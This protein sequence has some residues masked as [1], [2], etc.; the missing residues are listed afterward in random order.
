MTLE[1]RPKIVEGL[2]NF[3]GFISKKWQPSKTSVDVYVKAKVRAS[4]S[5]AYNRV[6]LS[7]SD[8]VET[9]V[10]ELG[11][12]LEHDRPELHAKIMEFYNRRTASDT[13]ES[14]SKVTGNKGYA[15]YEVTK[16]D[17]FIDA[18]IG[19][20]Y[21]RQGSSEILTMWF[22]EVL[23]NPTRLI[24]KDFDYFKFIFNLLREK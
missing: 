24:D 6:T 17:D 18:Y 19:K 23:T 11:H 14:L 7:P 15:A 5:K 8:G 9:M 20:F 13:I 22:T 4:Y 1:K 2:K 3:R 16:K 12:F 10:H 21:N